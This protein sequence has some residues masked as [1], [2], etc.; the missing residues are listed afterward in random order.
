MLLKQETHS[1]HR[2]FDVKN[3]WTWQNFLTGFS[4]VL[5]MLAEQ[6]L[7]LLNNSWDEWSWNAICSYL[8]VCMRNFLS[9]NTFSPNVNSPWITKDI[10]IAAK[11]LH[12]TDI[13][14]QKFID[15]NLKVLF[16]HCMITAYLLQYSILPFSTNTW[17]IVSNLSRRYFMVQD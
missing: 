11:G 1:S 7:S 6:T 17:F 5:L 12:W 13:L 16:F 10:L 15:S 3:A 2:V 8:D 14:T 9:R 4:E